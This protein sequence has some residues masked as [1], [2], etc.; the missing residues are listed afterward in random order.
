[1]T[2]LARSLVSHVVR[3][4]STP[5]RPHFFHPRLRPPHR[6]YDFAYFNPDTRSR[7][8]S[9]AAIA[10]AGSS[11]TDVNRDTLPIVRMFVPHVRSVIV[12]P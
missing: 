1:M 3:A 4:R 9:K 11:E 5:P 10:A 6:R 12:I 8:G 7:V 2:G